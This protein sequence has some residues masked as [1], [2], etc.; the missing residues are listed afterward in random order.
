MR[1]RNLV[2]ALLGCLAIVSCATP[3]Q[4]SPQDDARQITNTIT[5]WTAAFNNRNTATACSLFAPDFVSSYAGRPDWTYSQTCTL[6]TNVVQN[7]QIRYNYDIKVSEIKVSGDLAIVKAIWS[8]K[9][10]RLTDE[11]EQTH[12]EPTMDVFQRQADGKWKLIRAMGYTA[13][14]GAQP[15]ISAPVPSTVTNPT[16]TNVE[17]P[18][19][20]AAT[21]AATQAPPPAGSYQGPAQ[22]TQPGSSSPVATPAVTNPAATNVEAPPA[23]A[24]TPAATQ[25]PPP[26]GSYQGPAQATQPVSSSPVATPAVTNPTVTN[27]EAPPAAAAAPAATQAPPPTGDY[28][29]LAPEWCSR[30]AI[31]PSER[32]AHNYYCH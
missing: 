7:H 20:A 22:A 9:F 6:L 21:P 3:N 27:V 18:P 11:D 32:A 17:A 13:Q 15:F 5:T 16:A 30:P 19:A 24:A 31:T 29:G 1:V 26:A 2:A 4:T 8:L 25:A 28:Q 10:S 14:A 23:A 12:V